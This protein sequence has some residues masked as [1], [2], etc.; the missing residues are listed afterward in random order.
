MCKG[1]ID[2]GG[3]ALSIRPWRL[4]G[5]SEET[6]WWFHVKVTLENAPL[7]A[8]NEDSIKL[9]LGDHKKLL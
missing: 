1:C 6:V 7:E 8:W 3:S 2:I 4:A 5:G 9:I